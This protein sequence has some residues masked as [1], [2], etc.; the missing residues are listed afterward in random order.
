M[1]LRLLFL[2]LVVVLVYR[3]L[4]SGLRRRVADAS[5]KESLGVDPATI[6][7]AEFTDV[8]EKEESP[9]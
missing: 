2:A 6:R 7:D 5:R 3:A 1:T 9:R 4:R 8:S